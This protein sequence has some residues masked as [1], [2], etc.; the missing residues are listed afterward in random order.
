MN[1]VFSRLSVAPVWKEVIRLPKR[2]KTRDT[3]GPE[4]REREREKEREKEEDSLG[5][6]EAREERD[7]CEVYRDRER[8]QNRDRHGERKDRLHAYTGDR[9]G[10]EY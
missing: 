2:V 9:D 4:D 5:R 6:D 8:A 1:L 7:R 10:E 3:E